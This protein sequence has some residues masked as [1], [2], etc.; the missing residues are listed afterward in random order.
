M[1]GCTVRVGLGLG[2]RRPIGVRFT[3]GLGDS[4]WENPRQGGRAFRRSG[5]NSSREERRTL[6]CLSENLREKALSFFSGN[7]NNNNNN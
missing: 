1:L 2:L 6:K 7:N 4:D 5:D 3:I